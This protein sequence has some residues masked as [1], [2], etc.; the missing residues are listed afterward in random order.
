MKVHGICPALLKTP[1]LYQNTCCDLC[2]YLFCEEDVVYVGR[3][4]SGELVNVSDCCR[5]T[6]RAVISEQEHLDLDSMS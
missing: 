5:G 2:G 6:L 1:H 3:I 4:D